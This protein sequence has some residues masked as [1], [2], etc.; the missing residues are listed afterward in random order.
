MENNNTLDELHNIL[1]DTIRKL[2]KGQIN[3]DNANSI[4]GLSNAIIKNA[5]TQIQAYKLTRGKTPIPVFHETNVPLINIESEKP[6]HPEERI[7]INQFTKKIPDNEFD[8]KIIFAEFKG[9]KTP[10]GAIS[11]M[12]IEDFNKEYKFWLNINNK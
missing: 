1:F 5:K 12:G 8:R 11:K 3:R 4:C 10:A 7:K 2:N 6:V 9:Y